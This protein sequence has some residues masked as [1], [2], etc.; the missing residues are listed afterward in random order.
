MVR[1]CAAFALS[2]GVLL[3][4]APSRGAVVYSTSFE[5][6]PFTPDSQLLGQDGWSTAIPPFL[7]PSA[8]KIATFV[9]N[10]GQQYVRVLGSDLTPAAEVGPQYQA[11]GSYRRPVDYDTGATGLRLVRLQADVRLDGP[12]VSTGD[13]ATANIAARSADGT[14]GEMG[15]SSDDRIYGY[16]PSA[17]L[18][19]P[20]AVSVPAE[21]GRYYR[22]AMDVNFAAN[23]VQY[24]VDGT[25]VGGPLAF[26]AGFSSDVLQR[27]ALVA[28]SR[29]PSDGRQDHIYRWDNFSIAADVVPEPA[30]L[31]LIVLGAPLLLARRRAR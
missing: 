21:L 9:P 12:R 30:A 5:N 6:P 2:L 14:V 18:D 13:L 16:S 10:S 19:D 22:L 25:P 24:F 3:A 1:R 28:Y 17:G 26:P 4:A 15:V 7:N 8:A 31:G 23:T 27:G 20:P 29:I 11:V